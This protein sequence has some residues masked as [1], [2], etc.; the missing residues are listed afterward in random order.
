MLS[1]EFLPLEMFFLVRQL[2]VLFTYL[3]LYSSVSL[4]SIGGMIKTIPLSSL[5]QFKFKV[6]A[7]LKIQSD[8]LHNTG[9]LLSS[10]ASTFKLEK[11]AFSQ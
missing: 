8:L 7:G 6:I 4:Y 9:P 10:R 11:K 1:K 5:S 3:A 2:G